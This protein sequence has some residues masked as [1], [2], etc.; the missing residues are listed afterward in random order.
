M[1]GPPVYEDGL[2]EHSIDPSLNS[3]DNTFNATG[4]RDVVLFPAWSGGDIISF[5]HQSL[6]L[7]F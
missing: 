1:A 4:R 2:F 5:C 3:L 7:E 6:L